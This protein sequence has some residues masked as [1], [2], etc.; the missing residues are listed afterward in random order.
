MSQRTCV[1][2]A[3]YAV[4]FLE[5]F[6]V[7]AGLRAQSTAAS[8]TGKV[9]DPSGAAMPDVSVTVTSPAL[10]VPL[11]TAKTDTDGNY[12]VLE[13]PAP[14]VYRVTFARAGF[15]TLVRSDI[16]LSVGFTARVDVSMDVGAV[17]QT[18]EVTGASPVVDTVNTSGGTTL[19]Q[20]EISLPPRGVN[21]QELLPMVAGVSMAG[22]PDVG[23]SNMLNRSSIITY[24]VLLQPTL[25][26]EGINIATSHDLDTGAY[27]QSYSLAE[28]EF[29]TTGN[30]ADVAFPGVNMVAVMKSG[31]NS[32]HGSLLADLENSN[33]QAN[34]ITPALAAQ[35][36][37][38]TNPIKRYYD[39][40]IE[41]GGRIIR[42]K[43]WFYAGFNKQESIQGQI[44]F[45]SGPDAAGCWTCG[46]AP[47]A[48]VLAAL[49]QES[50]KLS[51][52][53][54]S[55]IRLIGTYQHA[56]KFY[57]AQSGSSTLPLPSTLYEH[58]P[59]N[60]YKGEVQLTPTPHLFVTGLFG[61]GGY[62]V[63]YTAQPGTD[64]PGNPSS[65]E[66]TTRLATGPANEPFD[67]PQNRYEARVT[68]SYIMGKHQFKFGT[69][70]TWEEGD[71]QVLSDKKSGDYQ[72][73]FNKGLPNQIN[74]FNYP[75]TPRNQLYS[76]SAFVTDSWKLG[77]VVLNYGVRWERY[78]AFYPTQT[79][80]AGQ[81]SA[82]AT[83]P[84]KDL[85]VWKDVVPRLGGAWD[86]FGKGKTVLKGSFGKFGDT[87]GDLWGNTFNPN[88]LVTTSYLWSGPCVVT[89][90]RNVSYNNTSC[91]VSPSTLATLNPSSPNFVTATGGLNELNDPKLKQNK[92]YEFVARL[93]R[94]LVPNVSLSLGYI[95]HRQYNLYTSGS[96][97]N[98]LRPYSIYT[99]PVK[100]TDALTGDPVTVFTYPSSYSSS[101]YNQFEL[102]NAPGNRP[103][104]FH[105]FAV[106][107]IKRYSKKWNVLTS[108]WMTKNHQWTQVVSAS[109]ND[110]RFPTD[111]N[112]NWEARASAFYDL[113]WGFQISGLF[114]AQS[115]AP[116][117]RT[118]S[119]SSPQLLQGAVTLR[120]EPYGAERGPVIPVA[121]VKVAKTFSLG[122]S[123]KL[124]WNFQLFNIFNSSAATSTSYLTGATYLR[125]TGILSPRVARVGAQFSF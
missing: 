111:N 80:P 85:L 109:P 54:K 84:G 10:Q 47:P 9:L 40:A 2:R 51:Y 76:Q 31:S 57:P 107:V 4:I 15:R 114:R 33:F 55:T 110:D 123:R 124:Q 60:A 39:Y 27:F 64:V 61:Y 71:T 42:D 106:E 91:D 96:G 98:I 12:Q 44:G 122:E 17:D 52:Q 25:N 87:M 21:M 24:Q 48:Y 113:P 36:L 101:S 97:I 75:F 70:D 73:L 103:D 18:I 43:L 34:N 120:M 49:P 58:Q 116:G 8:I 81:F 30:N 102:V 53:M 65:Q 90:Y 121:N 99:V 68:V 78:D 100:F 119:F 29:T 63:H 7:Q 66:L 22:K 1:C 67:R 94:Q 41:I 16:I 45:V 20:A 62:H 3:L 28:V 11:L 32:F 14:G 69:D 74:L 83:Y 118:E 26:F 59:E 115:G 112:W 105:T 92:V 77:R 50:V 93:E 108:F 72:L 5:V 23:D 89:P 35:G 86:I 38:F 37:K 13:L 19:Q 6:L 125:T 82:Q 104:T 56:N 95:H 88:A 79:K 46:D 117:G